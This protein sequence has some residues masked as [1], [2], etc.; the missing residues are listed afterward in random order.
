MVNRRMLIKIIVLLLFIN[1]AGNSAIF[2]LGNKAQTDP[3]VQVMQPSSDA[4]SLG[5]FSEIPVDLY[6][7]KTNINIP[8]F[9]I[10]CNDIKLPISISYHGGGIKAE[11]EASSVGLGWTLNASGVISRVVRGMPDDLFVNG[12]V[13]GYNNL[14]HLR[15]NS[16]YNQ[17]T[18][19]ISTIKN[20][21]LDTDPTNIIWSPDT[22]EL[23]LLQLMEHYGKLYDEG[24]FD[25]APDNFVFTVQDLNGAFV[26]GNTS[27]IQS[28]KGCYISQIDNGFQL[29]DANGLTYRFDSIEQQYYPYK[30]NEDLWLMDWDNLEQKKFLYTSAWWLSSIVSAAGDR[31]SFKYQ[32]IKKRRKFANFYAYT[33]YTYINSDKTERKESNFIN[34]HNDFLDTVHHQYTQLT[35]IYTE[36]CRLKFHYSLTS[37]EAIASSFIDSIS[38]YAK[39]AVGEILVERYK[40][41]YSG[42][43]NRSKLMS[44]IH[45]GRNGEVQ[46]YDFTYISPP[47]VGENNRDHWGY[48]SQD[49]QGT[50]PNE[51]QLGIIPTHFPNN[52]A[53]DRSAD[54]TYAT[55]NMLSSITYPSGLEVRLTWEP[56]DYSKW[57]FAGAKAISQD[58]SKNQPIILYDT[59]VSSEFELCG[60]ANKE[61]L[62]FDKDIGSNQ[63]IDVDL[64]HYFYDSN[65]WRL[66]GC[67]MN[68]RQEYTGDIPK[69]SIK[70]DG[71]EIYYSHLDSL[72]ITRN[73]NNK[74]KLHNL[75]R[76]NGGG[77]YTFKLEHP[78]YTLQSPNTD[79]CG[80]YHNFFNMTETQLGRIPITI[81]TL[82]PKE[83]PKRDSNVGGVRIKQIEY[84]HGN[85]L[86]L[87]K[88]YSY[89]DSLGNSTGVLSYRPR[90]A[91]S[92]AI[93][94]H[95]FI[96]NGMGGADGTDY[97][98][99]YAL[100]LRSN[101]LPYVLN[102]GGHIEYEKVTEV[103]TNSHTNA[104]S[105]NP[106]NKIEYYYCTSIKSDHSDIDETNYG[107]FVPTDM[108]QL[109]SR[110]HRRGH[111]QQKV[112]Y[113]DECKTTTYE[114]DVLECQDVDTCTGALFPTA[115]FQLFNY[116]YTDPSITINPYKNFG[117]VKYR[118]IPYNKR[119]ISQKTIGDKTNTYDTYTYAKNAYSTALNADMPLTHTYVT[120]EGDTLVE[121]FT[122]KDNTNKI[123]QCITTKNGHM[124]DGYRL[125]YDNAYRIT[126]KYVPLLS[127]TSLPT[128]DIW[129]LQETYNY[130]DSINKIDEVI[131]HL[132][133]ITT[134]YLWSYGGQYPIAKI[135]NSNLDEVEGKI[136]TN[137]VKGL[138]N[139]YNPDI[140]IVNT[141]RT[142]LPKANVVTMTYL[143]LVGMISYTDEKGYTLYYDYDGFGRIHEVYEVNSGTKNILKHYD[144]HIV[145]Q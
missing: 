80:E 97:N 8:L 145:N 14:K 133:N 17:F 49:S 10:S 56:H 81:Y 13:A 144:Y 102:G 11:E 136:G 125:E 82:Q 113:T 18:S 70:K 92:Y 139:T 41:V 47:A 3:H 22:S 108:L 28:N 1:L 138:Q 46:R 64:S 67:V 68:W 98:E 109:T 106:I 93:C 26:N 74:T 38:L 62:Y 140:S 118:V 78:R 19:F 9:T 95:T 89:K 71:V 76:S 45:Q 143:P 124:V 39:N 130:D 51:Q 61:V 120:S 121:H 7:G 43:S 94:Q 137:K 141:L 27:Q 104:Q 12:Q 63:R 116:N 105:Y 6:S 115:D 90:Y 36:H 69:F 142:K 31:I 30:V 60:K 5:N 87:C 75:V 24:H 34:P 114:Y 23:D 127:A 107:T 2:A 48:F 57:S 88:E 54:H 100:F 119:Q 32:T 86:Y 129:R 122:Y 134:T 79:C 50:F 112:E 91:S 4:Q 103:T 29:V 101:G 15:I 123:T 37:S 132:T 16:S 53:S 72:S 44:L 58:T 135:V 84:R 21:N 40:F 99:P 42:I 55:N 52:R 126:K 131:N 33:Q 96:E 110:R 111:L 117:I 77:T 59:I 73:M 83:N 85:T 25:S 35:D 128:D 20:K 65:V 66:M